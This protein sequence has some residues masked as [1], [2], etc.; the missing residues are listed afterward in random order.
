MPLFQ[1]KYLHFVESVQI[2]SFFW[3][4]FPVFGIS[5]FNPNGGGGGGGG[6]PYV[7]NFPAVLDSDC[8]ATGGV[9]PT[10]WS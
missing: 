9:L 3:S 8:T 2:R 5:I 7:E 6:G 10:S 1:L 4:V